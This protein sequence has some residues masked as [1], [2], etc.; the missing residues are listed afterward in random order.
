MISQTFLARRTIISLVAAAPFSSSLAKSFAK[1]PVARVPDANVWRQIPAHPRL[2]ASAQTFLSLKDRTDAASKKMQALIL[3]EAEKNLIAA[4]VEF[5]P[6]GVL[7]GQMRAIQGRILNLAMS[8]RLTGDQRFSQGARRELLQLAQLPE[9]RPSHF[10]GIGEGAL[11]AGIG[12]DWLYDEL[13]ES[14]REIIANAIVQNAILPSLE[15]P[16]GGKSWVDGDF[17]WTQVCH[18]GVV[19]GAMAIVERVPDLARKVV[20][21]ALTNFDNVGNS[22]APDGS[23][24]EGTDYWAYG[25]GFHVIIIEVLRST[26]GSAC[27]LDQYSGFLKTADYAWQMLAPTGK[28]YNYSDSRDSNVSEDP[29]MFWF[30]NE[31][32][33][34]SL[35]RDKLSQLG[36]QF[37]TYL[38]GITPSD[39]PTRCIHRHLAFEMLWWNPNLPP[40]KD[41]RA[42]HWTASG[43]LP[44]AVMRSAWDDK[45][46]SYIAIKGGTPNHS[47]AHMD[48]GSFILE[49]N[50]V[51]W[52]VDLGAENYN[53]MRRANFDLWDYSQ[54]SQRWSTFR[55][56][57]DGHNILMFDHQRQ[58][59]DGKAEVRALPA[60]DTAIGNV[61]ELTPLYRGQVQRVQRTVTLLADKSISIEDQWTTLAKDVTATWKW[62]TYAK[63]TRIAN[64]LL[65]EQA[66]QSL[67]LRIE[68]DSSNSKSSK[69]DIAIEDVSA[70]RAIQDSPNPGLRCIVIT[71]PSAA[72]SK[73]RLKVLAIPIA[74]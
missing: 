45:N 11:A 59:V 33:D 56:G 54:N 8:F 28:E 14:E 12:F 3:F 63:V 4:P 73:V 24:A 60:S 39:A 40:A 34:L 19:V 26:L 36:R 32:R 48:V 15:T 9:W 58:N 42:L 18:A 17:N 69:F 25:T 70:A 27:G 5:P 62:L 7:M 13:S 6:T 65:L 30:A 74:S 22:Y 55:V 47:H 57:P 43:V 52:A 66:G 21:R 23:H 16:A 44:L 64:G 68:L 31:R 29:V 49:A 10:L 50:G 71:I 41:S 46:A 61:V 2:F 1:S 53:T 67:V 51:R 72:H 37:S 20:E 38:K 35:L